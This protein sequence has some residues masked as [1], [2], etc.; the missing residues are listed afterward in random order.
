MASMNNENQTPINEWV[1]KTR[2]K[3]NSNP[4][5]LSAMA[6][7][8]FINESPEMIV[9]EA[10]LIRDAYLEGYRAAFEDLKNHYETKG[11]DAVIE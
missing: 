6:Y 8:E 9:K 10:Q 5:S 11:N 2:K 7:R 1:D 4:L 3:L